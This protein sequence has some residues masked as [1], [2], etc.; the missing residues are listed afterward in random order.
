M[1]LLEIPV[2]MIFTVDL[3]EMCVT[4]GI[5]L[6][7]LL[8]VVETFAAFSALI[9]D[10]P[11][12]FKDVVDAVNYSQSQQYTRAKS[13]FT[14]LKQLYGTVVFVLCWKLH[15]FNMLDLYL[16]TF[17]YLASHSLIRGVCYLFAMLYGNIIIEL[18]FTLYKDFVLEE[19]F[20]FNKK[21]LRVFIVDLVKMSVLTLLLAGPLILA[22]LWFFSAVG[23][24]AWV[25]CWSVTVFFVLF[26]AFVFPKYLLP[27]F[28]TL[29]PLEDGELKS[30]ISTLCKELDFE[31]GEV[32]VMDGST[33]SAHSNAFFAGFGKTK[34]IV[35]F[36]T[37][38][39]QQSRN[40]KLKELMC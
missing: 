18:P 22:I 32:Y 4:I 19:R 16:G 38:L 40:K 26:T 5:G 25:C 11:H 15:F 13:G 31:F 1:T 14:L 34:R 20:G 29:E 39:E 24:L 2:G 8:I 33:R 17:P 7:V 10:I 9:S 12:E 27:I 37:L 6:H 28:N 30:L 35:L 21:T 3:I 36:D 23:D